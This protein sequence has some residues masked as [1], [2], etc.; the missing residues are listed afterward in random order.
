MIKKILIG[1]IAGIISGLFSTGGGMIL[2]PAFIYFLKLNEKQARATS[3]M[4]VLT[5]VV[6]TSI[7]YMKKNYI[8]FELGFQCAIGGIIG[9]FLGTKIL[10]KMKDSSLK[11]IFII[12]IL[13]I[14]LKF[15]TG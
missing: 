1:F 8:N 7:F 5:I 15:I 10:N 12:F 2:V 9:G 6:T 13:Y 4:C 11:V 3:I 14:S